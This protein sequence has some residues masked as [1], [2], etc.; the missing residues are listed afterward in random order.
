MYKSVFM[1]FGKGD[2]QL[3]L[4]AD[5][6]VCRK[7]EGGPPP[8]RPPLSMAHCS[9]AEVNKNINRKV[10]GRARHPGRSTF[11]AFYFLWVESKVSLPGLTAPPSSFRSP[12]PASSLPSFLP[13]F[14]SGP[15]MSLLPPCCGVT[16][17]QRL[18]LAAS[19]V[20]TVV[21]SLTLAAPLGIPALPNGQ[22]QWFTALGSGGVSHG[23]TVRRFN[24]EPLRSAPLHAP[25]EVNDCGLVR[26]KGAEVADFPHLPDSKPK[27]LCHCTDGLAV[28]PT[29]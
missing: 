18:L 17:R 23:G 5:F 15:V 6:V 22:R 1:F 13:S 12:R 4:D 25:A 20:D 2:E 11:Y 24:A 16:D 29:R 21:M 26:E 9:V 3:A 19:P 27:P 10:A 14:L 28:R 8:P 7:E